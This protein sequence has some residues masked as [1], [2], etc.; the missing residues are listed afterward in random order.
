[1]SSHFAAILNMHC[2]KFNIIFIFSSIY[3]TFPL[4]KTGFFHIRNRKFWLKHNVLKF[5]LQ[6]SYK[7][8][9]LKIDI[10]DGFLHN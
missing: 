7:I 6:F 2:L 3:L 5:L 4:Q 1:M 9:V 8:A 10:F